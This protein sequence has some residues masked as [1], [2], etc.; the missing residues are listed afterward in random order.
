MSYLSRTI[1]N[2]RQIGIKEAAHQM[3][4][5]GDTKAGR[6]VGI[7]KMGN[8]YYENNVRDSI[9]FHWPALL[10]FSSG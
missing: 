9:W 10:M 1:K 6:L 4:H 8:K 5:I 7:D 3:Q 2:I